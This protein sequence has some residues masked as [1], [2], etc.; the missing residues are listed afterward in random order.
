MWSFRYIV[1]ILF[2]CLNSQL[3]NGQNFEII[4]NEVTHVY[5]SLN[6][7]VFINDSTGFAVGG[8]GFGSGVITKTLDY[9][10][11]W[12]KT[13]VDH[14]LLQV[15]FVTDSI[16]Y[17]VGE[18]STIMKT[19]DAGVTWEYQNTS[20][21]ADTHTAFTVAFLNKDT[22]FVAL[23]N[24]PSFA[25]LTTY[26]GGDTWEN[27]E[28]GTVYGRSRMQK[29]N[30]STVYAL[31]ND[32]NFYRTS[33]YGQSWET[34]PLP[35]PEGRSRDMHFFDRDTGIVAIREFDSNCGNNYYLAQTYDGGESWQSQYYICENF[36]SF[37][38]PTREIGFAKGTYYINTGV[39]TY[40]RTADGGDTWEE[41][42]FP[43]V[44]SL[45]VSSSTITCFAFV[46]KD[47]CYM[48]TN[49]GT[50]IK[51]TNATSGISSVKEDSTPDSNGILIYPNPND[52]EF[53]ISKW[54]EKEEISEIEI[55]S[56]DGRKVY[57]E[58]PTVSENIE[59]SVPDLSPGIY[60]LVI[61]SR[62]NSYSG[63]FV[64]L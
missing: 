42:E 54:L 46:N 1:G 10:H 51:M 3:V 7:A 25:F 22:G 41:R 26:N 58:K 61:K 20:V 24:G 18:R 6:D 39:R 43:G 11:S 34:V 40:W 37:S 15:T 49:Y 44:D 23:A 32:I 17:A 60:T 8:Y 27:G 50:I 38:F 5:T 21:I 16:G 56:I 53:R 4:S 62:K 55:Y 64:K 48:P 30:D 52:G 57:Q 59:I 29:I 12:I 31:P 36:S 47:T 28:P 45:F 2:F 14:D 19:M 33:D 63:K 13:E 9:G 35:H